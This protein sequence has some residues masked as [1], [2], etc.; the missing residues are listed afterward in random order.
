MRN[1]KVKKW[2]S[3]RIEE[4]TLKGFVR[5]MRQETESAERQCQLGFLRVKRFFYIL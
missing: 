1:R 5:E 4:N 3:K 2:E